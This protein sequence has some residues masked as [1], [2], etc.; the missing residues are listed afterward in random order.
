MF[1]LTLVKTWG[2]H[3]RIRCKNDVWLWRSSKG[4]SQPKSFHLQPGEV[5]GWHNVKL[6]KRQWYGPV[7]VIFGRNN[8]N[9]EF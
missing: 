1:T 5:F 9:G 6:H 2:W 8:V 4:W 3:Y 7:H